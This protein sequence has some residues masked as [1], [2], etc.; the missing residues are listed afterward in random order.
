MHGPIEGE[1]PFVESTAGRQIVAGF[2]GGSLP[3]HNAC[4][5]TYLDHAD[6]N[7]N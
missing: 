3:D 7:M 4:L 1:M 5:A 2:R 6:A